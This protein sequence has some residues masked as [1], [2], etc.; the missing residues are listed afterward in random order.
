MEVTSGLLFHLKIFHSCHIHAIYNCNLRSVYE[1]IGG[2]GWEGGGK[3]V[4]VYDGS[5]Y[6]RMQIM[7]LDG[8]A[9]K[10]TALVSSYVTDLDGQLS[11][12]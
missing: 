11:E 3:F 7:E 4:T 1:E 6:A 10:H 2:G 9:A 8:F 12:F 5:Y